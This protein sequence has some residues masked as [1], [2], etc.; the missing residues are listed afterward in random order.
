MK[1]LVGIPC[2]LTGG[3]EIQTLSLVK[4]L[5]KAGHHVVTVCY[6]EHITQMVEQYRQVGAEVVCLQQ[7]GR[8]IG[9]W[10]GVL[11]LWRGLKMVVRRYRPDVAHVQYMA[12]GAIPIVLFRLL[13]VRHIIA[14][15]HTA[16]D[17][18][19][20]L[21][22]VHFVQAH[23]VRAFTCITL[24]AEQSFFG[25]SQLYTH[26]TRL[27]KRNHFTI[28]NALPSYIAPADSPRRH[29]HTPL[30]IGV[31]SRLESIKGMD[32]V[33]PAFSEVHRHHP[34]TRLLVV[35]DGTLRQ[36]ME[37]QV[38]EC[39]L[40]SSVMFVGRQ[41][42]EALQANY[43]RIDILWM[44]SRSEG[45]GLTALE[46]MARGCVVIAANVGGLPEV[47]ED[48]LSGILHSP[49]NI[50]DIATKTG[51]LIKNPSLLSTLSK[52]AVQRATLFSSEQY[53]ILIDS[54]YHKLDSAIWSES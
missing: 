39:D 28:Y 46:G 10:R 35:G 21:R 9:G 2:L 42:Q 5:V 37:E 43:D 45:F 38:G 20:T 11:F 12:P 8:R 3:T 41:P 18:Y 7:E 6:F 24:R 33:I 54:L 51:Q 34:D 1:V 40:S 30:T 15:A 49:E 27:G 4:A 32:L 31:V 52:A 29:P 22:L 26:D 44:P 25:S 50:H 19:P 17:I 16:A 13:G 47:I 23:L 48:G 14:T 36:E 53:D